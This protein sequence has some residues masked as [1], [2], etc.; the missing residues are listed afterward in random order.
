MAISIGGDSPEGTSPR[1]VT[2]KRGGHIDP[3]GASPRFTGSKRG[4]Y[5][6]SGFPSPEGASTQGPSGSSQENTQI[7]KVIPPVATRASGD[8]KTRSNPLKG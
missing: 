5:P 1:K 7:A 2:D 6:K 4:A 3:E 8:S